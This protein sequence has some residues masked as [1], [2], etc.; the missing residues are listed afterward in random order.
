MMLRGLPNLIS[1]SRVVATLVIAAG[2]AMHDQATVVG[3]IAYSLLSDV[4]DG[5]LARALGE[6]SA[7]GAQLDSIADAMLLWIAPA[8]IWTSVP[9]ARERLGVTIAVVYASYVVPV[10]AGVI[11]FRRLTSYHTWGARSAAVLIAMGFAAF[12]LWHV[13]WPLGIGVAVLVGSAIEEFAIT[14]TLPRWQADVRSLM[15][16][17]RLRRQA[18]AAGVR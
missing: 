6:A 3:G 11:K 15:A 1:G 4:I 2:G 13:V 14:C 5:P 8:A 7:R 10:A 12:L 9:G 16:A 18:A 17:V